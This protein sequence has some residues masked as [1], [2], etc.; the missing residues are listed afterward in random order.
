DHRYI[1]LLMSAPGIGWVTGF[2]IAAEIG[3][4][5]RFSSPVKLTGYTGL[6]PREPVRGHGPPRP[7]VQARPQISALG[8][9][10]S[11]DPRLHAPA[12]PRPPQHPPPAGAPPA[13]MPS[14]DHPSQPRSVPPKHKG[15]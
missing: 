12:A 6:C 5:S 14:G 11:S 1:P 9:H 15:A 8:A 2:T 4:I 13:S 3:D 10:G 7:A